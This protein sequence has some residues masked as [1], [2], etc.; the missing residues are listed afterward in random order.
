M[1]RRDDAGPFDIIGDIHGCVDELVGLLQTLGYSVDPLPPGEGLASA[2]HPSGRRVIFVGDL[3]DRGPA[4]VDVLRYAMGMTAAGTAIGVR[5]NHD[6][7]LERYLRGNPVRL[8]HGLQ[9]TVDELLQTSQPFRDAVRDHIN[10]MAG[11]LWLD[12][13]ALLVAHAGLKFD[14]F[15]E[16]SAR[17]RRFA[18]YGEMTGEIDESG[19]P[20]RVDW[21]SDYRGEA[22][23]VYGHTPMPEARRLNGTVCIDTGCVFG[24]ALTALRWPENTLVSVPAARAYA[25][26]RRWVVPPKDEKAPR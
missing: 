24:G 20:V 2:R 3:T 17:A 7:K 19:L 16:R 1:D 22:L 9:R 10:T 8:E 4:N 25:V 15:G 26:S 13:G 18:M 12:G 23:L 11:H 5:G 21:A 14:M 6:D